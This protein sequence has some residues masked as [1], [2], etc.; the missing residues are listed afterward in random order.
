[1][2][3]EEQKLLQIEHNSLKR[4]YA[5]LG[6][7]TVKLEERVNVLL[8]EKTKTVQLTVNA[9]R[10]L[11]IQKT[12]VENIITSNAKRQQADAADIEILREKIKELKKQLEK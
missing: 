2:N 10:N 8:A 7:A 5:S 3:E 4:R 11:M 9:E 12:I 1:M 6:E